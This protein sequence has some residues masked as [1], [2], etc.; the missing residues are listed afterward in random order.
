MSEEAPLRKSDTDSELS[1]ENGRSVIDTQVQLLQSLNDELI[2]TVRIH[3]LMGGGVVAAITTLFSRYG[4]GIFLPERYVNLWGLSLALVVFVVYWA[5]GLF[6]ARISYTKLQLGVGSNCEPPTY[7]HSHQNESR[8]RFTSIWNRVK[9]FPSRFLAGIV[10]F[11][12]FLKS[13]IPRTAEQHEREVPPEEVNPM[14]ANGYQ[15]AIHHNSWILK[16]RENYVNEVQQYL[17]V[18]FLFF[19]LGVFGLIAA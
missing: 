6:S 14:L 16:T 1:S 17:S 19:V 11:L 12:R 3:I 15:S 10:E 2:R 7:N 13:P 5:I 4:G 18:T 8:S 9:T